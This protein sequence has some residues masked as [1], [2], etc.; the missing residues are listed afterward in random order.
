MV[1]AQDA[2]AVDE[3]L[4][5]VFEHPALAP[6]LH[7]HLEAVE[8]ALALPD[9]LEV[10]GRF[11]EQTD[12]RHDGLARLRGVAALPRAPRQVEA[13]EGGDVR[14]VASLGH[15]RQARP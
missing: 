6:D 4:E 3:A 13:Y 5:H 10:V 12:A 11:L 9:R 15:V 1:L 2:D 8:R 14:V 7:E